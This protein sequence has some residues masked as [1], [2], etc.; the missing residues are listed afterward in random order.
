M[1]EVE[2]LC[3]RVAIVF[4]GELR[5]QGT[6]SDI[7]QQTQSTTLEQAFFNILGQEMLS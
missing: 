4:R 5:V 1:S 2:E 6:L 7:K 3:D